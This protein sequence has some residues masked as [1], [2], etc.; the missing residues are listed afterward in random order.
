MTEQPQDVTVPD[1][2]LTAAVLASQQS[3]RGEWACMDQLPPE[4]VEIPPDDLG[5]VDLGEVKE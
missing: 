3:E 5:A 1:E 2:E 4:G